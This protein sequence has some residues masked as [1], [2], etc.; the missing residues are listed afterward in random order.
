MALIS[1][2]DWRISLGESS[3]LTRQ[4]DGWARYGSYPPRAD[5]MSHSTPIPFIMKKAI[6][7]FGTPKHPKKKH[8]KNK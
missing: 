3:P 7:E 6:D 4:R 8:K 5:I 2:K 1:F